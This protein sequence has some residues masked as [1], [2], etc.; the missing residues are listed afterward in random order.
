MQG[1]LPLRYF[2]Y[3]CILITVD[4]AYVS[5]LPCM[6][7]TSGYGDML[8][9]PVN[10][11]DVLNVYLACISFCPL[12]ATL[13]IYSSMLQASILAMEPGPSAPAEE[14]RGSP[15]NTGKKSHPEEFGHGTFS[16]SEKGQW[17][18]LV[19]FIMV[20]I[21]TPIVRGHF[22]DY[23]QGKLIRAAL[24]SAVT[25][26]CLMFIL[27]KT[28]DQFRGILL[29][30]GSVH[31]ADEDDDIQSA[32]RDANRTAEYVRRSDVSVV[33]VL[34]I[35][36]LGFMWC[37]GVAQTSPPL[38]ITQMDDLFG[39]SFGSSR[40]A[41]QMVNASYTASHCA[42][43][44]GYEGRSQLTCTDN[45]W[46]GNSYRSTYALCLAERSRD[47]TLSKFTGGAS[48]GV[49]VLL[50]Y[51]F[52]EMTAKLLDEELRAWKPGNGYLKVAW[53][54]VVVATVLSPSSSFALM[55]IPSIGRVESLWTGLTGVPMGLWIVAFVLL[56]LSNIGSLI[57]LSARLTARTAGFGVSTVERGAKTLFGLPKALAKSVGGILLVI[58][59]IAS[60]DDP[61]EISH[62]SPDGSPR[63]DS[64]AERGS[65]E[66]R[67]NSFHQLQL[68]ASGAHDVQVELAAVSLE[69]Q[70]KVVA[71][72]LGPAQREDNDSKFVGACPELKFGE[73]ADT[74]QGLEH[75]LC[76]PEAE[77]ALGMSEGVRAIVDEIE[78]EGTDEDK[79]CL[80]YVRGHPFCC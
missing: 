12:L 65:E 32:G 27:A 55:L 8:R 34:T 16:R 53:L 3:I 57:R 73:A 78:R 68:L 75:L 13:F 4:V 67:R 6:Q 46:P 29:E 25:L 19:C 37:V 69:E 44:P 36:T 56:N 5:S 48:L 51:L 18:S 7:A 35:Q 17:L 21:L 1:K 49:Y 80:K 59:A 33:C 60:T 45:L 70:M 26:V 2:R 52:K 63:R 74:V 39:H 30:Y 50:A 47:E 11:L 14:R 15:T 42:L 54:C 23:F 28:A 20:L 62:V 79:E 40:S 58:A 76:V 61:S 77:L 38:L 9:H 41:C 72:A 10:V 71:E 24:M 22:T 64:F 43:S 31:E 66:N